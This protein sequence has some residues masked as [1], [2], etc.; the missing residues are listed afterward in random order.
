VRLGLVRHEYREDLRE[1]ERLLAELGPR[2][3]PVAFVEDEVED[4]EYGTQP[5]GKQMIGWHAERDPR[6]SNLPLRAHE[7]LSHRRLRDE[8]GLRDLLGRKAA[9]RAQRQRDLRLRGQSRVAARE[10]QAQLLVGNHLGLL[11]VA[12]RRQGRKE[13]RLPLEGPLAPDPVDRTVASGCRQPGAGVVGHSV[14]GPALERPRHC[15][16]ESVLGE[17]EVAEDADQAR[18]HAPPLGAEDALELGQCSTTGL[19]SIA[20]PVRAAGIFE[21]NSIASSR[22]SHSTR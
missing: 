2:R 13:L 5:L 20:P 14:D 15:V 19:T 22:F 10:D 16:L 18:E 12:T 21:A 9:E 17:V 3:R 1:T 6:V 7:A 8:K 4:R 11:V